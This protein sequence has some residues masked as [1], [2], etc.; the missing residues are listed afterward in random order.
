MDSSF[1]YNQIDVDDFDDFYNFC[2]LKEKEKKKNG[3]R[4]GEEFFE[5]DVKNEENG[6][7]EGECEES[8]DNFSVDTT[9]MYKEGSKKSRSIG[10]NSKEI[11]QTGK[12][13]HEKRMDEVHT[14]EEDRLIGRRILDL[15]HRYAYV[16]DDYHD[17]GAEIELEDESLADERISSYDKD[18]QWNNIEYKTKKKKNQQMD[19]KNMG[20]NNAHSSNGDNVHFPQERSNCGDHTSNRYASVSKEDYEED[21]EKIYEDY[22]GRR[23]YP[24]D[25][26]Q[27]SNSNCDSY[28]YSV[29][30]TSVSKGNKEEPKYFRCRYCEMDSVD[31]VVQ[32]NTCGRWFCNGSY[33][34]CGSHIVTHLVRS[35]HKEIKL[36]KKSLLGETILECYNCGCKN[37]FLLGFLPTPEEGV[38]VI[39]CR[40]P[41]LARCISLSEKC[42]KSG[43][44]EQEQVKK[45]ADNSTGEKQKDGKENPAKLNNPTGRDIKGEKKKALP[46][47]DF[48]A[49][50]ELI[51]TDEDDVVS[52]KEDTD[53]VKNK[54]YISSDDFGYMSD[55]EKGSEGGKN[56][57]GV[58]TAKKSNQKG[59]EKKMEHDVNPKEEDSEAGSSYCASVGNNLKELIKMK[60]WDL[61]KWQPVIEDRCLLEW[62]VNIPTAEEAE[63]KGKRTTSYNVNKL[64][65]LWKNKKDV[66]IDELDGEILNDE[67]VKVE[68]RYKDAY[69][70][71]S[72]FAPLI[73]LEAD[74]DKS[75]KEGQKQAN[76]TVRWDI[77]LNKKRYAHFIYVKE[78]SELRLVAGD[79][80]KLSYTYPDGTIW[81]CEGHI[82]RI[83]NTE[84]IALEL[85]TS[86]TANGPWVD[87]ITTGYTVE[88]V[89]KS[90]AY[91]R[92]QL[93]LNEFA[94]NSYSLS[95]Y[96]YHKL[97]GHEVSEDSLNY[98]KAALT[99]QIHGKRT[100]RIAN[101]SAPN[102]AA[103]NHS[104]IDAIK[105]SLVSPLSLIQGPPGTGKT[106]TCATLV[107]HLSKTKMGKVLVTAPS[108]VAVD[109]LSVRIHKTGLKVVRL[110]AKSREYVPSIADYLY[111]HN[112]MKLIKSDIGE[113]LNKLLELKEEVGELSQKD[114]RRLKKLIFFAEYKILVEADVICTTC[115]GAMDKRL[116]RF[117]FS[118][119]LV[120]EATQST[121]PECLVPLVTG[122]KQIVLVG[123]HCQLGPIIVCKKA[124]NAGLGK[125]LFERLVMLGITPFRLEVQYRM[126]PA[127]SEFPSYVFY[128]GCL[129]NGITLKEREYPLKDF[130]WPNPKCP[131]FF[132]NSTGLEEMSAS[133]TSYLNRA[134]ASN[135]EKLVRTLINCGLKPSQIGVITPYE[136]QRAYIT[137]LFQ[138]NISYQHST[139]IEVA[140]VDAFQGREKDFILLSCVRSNKKLGIGFLNDPRRL[141]VALTRAK[142]GLIICGNAKVLSRHHVMIKKLHNSNETITNVNSVWINLLSQFKKKDL[143]VEGC[144]SNLKP[145]NIHIPTP[146]K[147][148]SRYINFSYF[149]SSERPFRGGVFSERSRSRSRSR[150]VGSDKSGKTGRSE[151]SHAGSDDCKTQSSSSF[152]HMNM[153]NLSYCSDE[154]VLNKDILSYMHQ[155][156]GG[157]IKQMGKS[158]INNLSQ[159]SQFND[160]SSVNKN[161]QSDNFSNY[162]A[163]SSIS[164]STNKYANQNLMCYN[165]GS[166]SEERKNHVASHFSNSHFR[167]NYDG[168][169]MRKSD[170]FAY[171]FYY[172]SKRD[173]S[174]L[175]NGQGGYRSH[176][177]KNAYTSHNP[178]K[179]RSNGGHHGYVKQN[180][181]NTTER[182]AYRNRNV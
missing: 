64:E 164:V 97:L 129:Q 161:Y 67:P 89:W 149:L 44:L 31:S 43:E 95:G 159:G 122:A 51:G 53:M 60:D 21:K 14:E 124:A 169:F 148:P 45:N 18:D 46:Y 155:R 132:Y 80:L 17:I 158:Y 4:I 50:E 81:S 84:E 75:I 94:Q 39:I 106:L 23:K 141:N 55:Q 56:S 157:G 175:H 11:L 128:D 151:G 47:D 145:M 28:S 87:N 110:C 48:N 68:L 154:V 66:Y 92:M 115:V 63:R 98:Y 127:L 181:G 59:K 182:R 135:M 42:Q 180:L 116:K 144:L 101:Y 35:K 54:G 103:L 166:L 13:S 25:C 160:Y 136:G 36:H 170:M 105:K 65:E 8:T 162:E 20:F 29:D 7:D 93:A 49:E 173:P 24:R 117:R 133:G 69:H 62:L 125:S 3:K 70:Y 27:Y 72:I 134:E 91:D 174:S 176:T 83:H 33:G 126:H 111:L 6:E 73:Q 22:N 137:S 119:V 150:S 102:L 57:H 99:N 152:I 32:C 139:E 16:D 52:T 34:T 26:S 15:E 108:N 71:Q 140:S 143:I 171:P 168:G 5:R 82:S 9:T 142:Y 58:F 76:V 40:D 86:N 88:F 37:V 120:D 138:K 179:P 178:R 12:T 104:Q 96:L 167:E 177:G 156:Q 165:R 130:P 131:M 113:E 118:Q 74:Y 77:G 123:D 90:T 100:P 163:E 172:G 10:K 112:Q 19:G 79:E 1:D 2:T 146:T 153:S 107:Y 114:E 78:E 85:R 121:E 61:N 30:M 147:Q 109:Q 41:C 38:V